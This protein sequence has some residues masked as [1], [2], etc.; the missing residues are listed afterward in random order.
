MKLQMQAIDVVYAYRQVCSV[1][2][3]LKGMRQESTREF[4]KIFVETAKLGEDLHG[5]QFQLCKPRIT[6]RQVHR[7]NPVTASVEDYFRITL[8][9]EFLSHVVGIGF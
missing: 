8:Y 6:R 3:I 7:S 2:S 5:E 4:G 9:D 1:I